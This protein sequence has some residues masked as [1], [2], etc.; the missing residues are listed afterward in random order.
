MFIVEIKKSRNPIPY[1]Y[2]FTNK[3]DAEDFK[4]DCDENAGPLFRWSGI[5][6][7]DEPTWGQYKFVK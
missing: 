6:E 3:K 2:G 5:K 7:K 4:K 1:E